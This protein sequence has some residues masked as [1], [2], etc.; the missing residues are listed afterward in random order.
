MNVQTEKIVRDFAAAVRE[1]LDDLPGEEIDDLTDG[2]VAD[3]GDRVSEGDTDLGDP[4]AYADEL[5]RAAGLGERPAEDPVIE[6]PSPATRAVR[7]I[8]RRV[9]AAR[10]TAW[11]RRIAVVLDTLQ[12]M[13]WV[14][15]GLLI[16]QLGIFV[17]V[18]F[19]SML[20]NPDAPIGGW[21]AILVGVSLSVL[22]GRNVTRA[23][24]WWR[25]LAIVANIIAVLLI[26]MLLTTVSDAITP[27]RFQPEPVSVTGADTRGLIYN[28]EP[29]DNVFPY[30]CTGTPITGVQLYDGAGRP[31]LLTDDPAQPYRHMWQ[32]EDGR[33]RLLTPNLSGVAENGWNVVPLAEVPFP[34][35]GSD[36]ILSEANRITPP[37]HA[38]PGLPEGSAPCPAPVAPAEG[39]AP[40]E[41]PAEAPAEAPVDPGTPAAPEDGAGQ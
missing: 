8:R 31:L 13:W 38:A 15:R 24:R 9:A 21:I 35:D 41:T 3:L 7:A 1:R 4:L 5:R 29:V 19:T 20:P 10:E 27:Y 39:A 36:P 33:T 32:T 23:P 2:L 22:W 28:G 16:A 17:A 6:A 34:E 25:R 40:A 11:W 18:P 14:L 12:P 37:L 26:P 30:D